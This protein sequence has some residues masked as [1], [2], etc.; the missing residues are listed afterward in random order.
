M[1]GFL[2]ED[3]GKQST[4]RLL[5]I[6]SFFAA[7]MFG[8]LAILRPDPLNNSLYITLFFG[9]G[10]YCPKAI[11]KFMETKIGVKE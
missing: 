1:S 11:Q 2:T 9:L 10:A 6:F 5:S 4:I 7:V 8:L 3:N